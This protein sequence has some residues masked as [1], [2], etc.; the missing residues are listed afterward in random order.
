MCTPPHYSDRMLFINHT[1]KF[2]WLLPYLVPG[3]NLVVTG[4][5]VPALEQILWWETIAS[6]IHIRIILTI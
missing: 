3:V 2:C 5:L 6:C 4:L 1:L